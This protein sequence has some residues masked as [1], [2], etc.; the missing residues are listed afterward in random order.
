MNDAVSKMASLLNS[1]H[2]KEILRHSGEKD[3]STLIANFFNRLM[4]FLRDLGDYT[5]TAVEGL[6]QA[7]DEL[8]IICTL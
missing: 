3:L 7:R 2:G 1:S 5:A 4:Q 8:V 6:E